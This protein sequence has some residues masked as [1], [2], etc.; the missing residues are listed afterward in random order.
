MLVRI[1]SAV[2][3]LPALLAIVLLCL[4]AAGLYG[5]LGVLGRRISQK[6]N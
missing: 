4:L 3:L 2:V 6:F 1:L 5:L